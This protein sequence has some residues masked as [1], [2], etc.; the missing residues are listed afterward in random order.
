MANHHHHGHDLAPP[1]AG[2]SPPKKDNAAELGSE[3]G[4]E[5]QKQA[6][7]G[8][9]AETGLDRKAFAT[10]QASFVSERWEFT[11]LAADG[12]SCPF[13]ATRWGMARLLATMDEAMAFAKSVGAC[14]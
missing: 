14:A 7:G 5:G 1:P 10:L 11:S 2:L 13:L 3:G 4:A 9:C 8:D 12:C 6:Y